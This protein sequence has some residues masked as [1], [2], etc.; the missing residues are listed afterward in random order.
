M[1]PRLTLA[2]FFIFA[3]ELGNEGYVTARR[4]DAFLKIP[5]TE[6]TNGKNTCSVPG[7]VKLDQGNF[8]WYGQKE[9]TKTKSRKNVMMR[10]LSRASTQFSFFLNVTVDHLCRQRV[11][12]S[13]RKR[14]LS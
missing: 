9:E 12:K 10:A 4:L 13:R 3:V 1:L 11:E 5:E 6:T 2:N 7:D 8:G 14:C